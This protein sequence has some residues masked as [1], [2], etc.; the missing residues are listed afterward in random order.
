MAFTGATIARLSALEMAGIERAPLKDV[1]LFAVRR[2]WVFVKAPVTPFL[3]LLA[4]GA[5]LVAAGL[6]GAVPFIGEIILGVLY[7]VLIA[8]GFV[9][10]LLL[11]GILGGFHLLYPTIAVEGSDAFD[12]MSRAFAYVYARPWRLLFYTVVSLIYGVITFLFVSFAIYLVLLLTH[13]FVG[14]G[15]S[16]FGYN[17]GWY[18]GL[19]KFDTLWPV[20]DLSRMIDTPNWYAMSWTEF[21]GSQFLHFWVYMLVTCTGAYVVSY[22]FSTHTIIYLLLRRSVDGQSTTEVFLEEGDAASVPVSLPA[23]TTAGS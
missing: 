13:T 15:T 11:L 18:S 9:M 16:V 5:L 12:A 1:M 17:H 3:I 14:W 23:G 10:M 8:V 20:P 19:P 6:V 7:I 22:Y 21:I 4:I 2:L